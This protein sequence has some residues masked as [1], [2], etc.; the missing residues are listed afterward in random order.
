MMGIMST[1]RDIGCLEVSRRMVFS[2]KYRLSIR[3]ESLYQFIERV[4]ILYKRPEDA[5][6]WMSGVSIRNRLSILFISS[7]F[8]FSIIFTYLIYYL[9]LPIYY[10]FFS[11]PVAYL[12]TSVVLNVYLLGLESDA[13][14][15]LNLEYPI[16]LLL[17]AVSSRINM[18]NFFHLVVNKFGDLLRYTSRILGRWVIDYE[19]SESSLDNILF[20]SLERFKESMF[21]YFVRDLV[22]VRAYSGEVSKFLE[23]ALENLYLDISTN[24]EN[25]WRNMVGRLEVILLLFG[26]S[27][28]IIMSVISIAS[29]DLVSDIFLILA[30]LIPVAGYIIYIYLDRSLYRLPVDAGLTFN[31]RILLFTICLSSLIYLLNYYGVFSLD[32]FEVFAYSIVVLIIYPSIKSLYAWF[33]ERSID[34]DLSNFLFNLEDMM[35]N[36]FSIREALARIEVNGFGRSFKNIVG[37][38][39]HYFEFGDRWS[40]INIPIYSRLAKLSIRLITYISDMGGGLKEIIF[41]RKLSEQYMRLKRNKFSSALLPLV[42][43]VMIVF[44]GFYNFWILETIFTQSGGQ[45]IP[46]YSLMLN[47]F[48]D[49]ATLYKLIYLESILVSGLL[50]SKSIHNDIH[51]TYPTLILLLAYIISLRIFPF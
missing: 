16:F 23:N 5:V 14:N 27:P 39:K 47:V 48:K 29:S 43:G 9:D 18:Y 51:Y 36:G 3:M 2:G 10:H 34:R 46:A 26:L 44:L 21:K 45:T 37:R 20:S 30:I 35:R 41:L 4:L 50:I 22:R 7:I 17:Y 1:V 38:M 15:S 6:P 25:N 32:Y 8:L 33:L 19:L 49:A 11:L 40:L 24:W 28:A 13:N 31:S 42:T 12:F